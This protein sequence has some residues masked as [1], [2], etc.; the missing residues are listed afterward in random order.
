MAHAPEQYTMKQRDLG[1]YL[2]FFSNLACGSLANRPS[3]RDFAMNSIELDTASNCVVD[4]NRSARLNI[5]YNCNIK[6][7]CDSKVASCSVNIRLIFFN[8]FPFVRIVSVLIRNT[9][10]GKNGIK[11]MYRIKDCKGFGLYQQKKW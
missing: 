8:S 5:M 2:I 3:T 10:N 11:M 4:G 9:W 6:E 7:A 1:K